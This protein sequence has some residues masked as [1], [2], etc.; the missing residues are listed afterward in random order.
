MSKIILKKEYI[1]IIALCAVVVFLFMD[2]C[3]SSRKLDNLRGQY[4][5]ASRIAKVEKMIKEETIKEQEREIEVL[6][7]TIEAKNTTIVKKEKTNIELD[8]KVAE[9]EDEFTS[10]EQQ[11]DKI[12]NL[13]QQ[14]EVWRE[15]FSLAQGIITDKD[16]IIF[17]L[18]K[19]YE[20]Q[21]KISDSYKS[22]YETLRVNTKKLEKIVTVQ[23][24][25]IRIL[26]L[27]S[28]LKTGIVAVTAGV[29]LYSLLRR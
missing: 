12:E 16:E 25:Q 9:L 15:K 23:D 29:I 3:G 11:V 8:G 7:T 13:M 19:K 22:M 28:K 27:T 4:E 5:E 1:L 17:S 21:L 24:R 18:N 26:K 2:K 14:V 6:N 20:A 10:L